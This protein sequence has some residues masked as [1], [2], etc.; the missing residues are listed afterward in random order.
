MC[1]TIL[2]TGS[3][4][5]IGSHTVNALLDT[6]YKVIGLDRRECSIDKANYIHYKVELSDLLKMK[7]II[8][9][10]KIDRVIHL[11]A[12]AH[13]AGVKD[14]S[15][16]AYYNANVICSKNI[17][18]IANECGIPVLFI[19]TV[20]VYGFTKGVVNAYSP[21]NPV[22]EYGKTK[23]LAEKACEDICRQY[24][25]FRFSPVYTHEVKR[26]IQKRYYFKYPNW[27]YIVGKGTEYEI[28]NI[29][30]AVSEMVSWCNAEVK[31]DIRIIKDSERMNTAQYIKLEKE[32]GRAKHT[33][34]FPRWLVKFGYMVTRITG[35]NKYTYLL[36]KVV[37]P[38]RT[39]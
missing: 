11:A 24:T 37:N 14:L 35:K 31:N 13:T 30:N 38:L 6:G 20:D 21:L 28:L 34:H 32:N 8:Y 1:K 17:F 2:I 4:G 7:E 19:S 3:T 22:T 27:A 12:L 25:I 23:E 26:D 18:N 15:Y 29:E 9:N 39:E 5:M 33:L 10:N 36:N 16:K